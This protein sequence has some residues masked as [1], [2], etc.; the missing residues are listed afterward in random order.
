MEY[1]FFSTGGLGNRPNRRKPSEDCTR[2]DHDSARQIE[3][4][5]EWKLKIEP[6]VDTLEEKVRELESRNWSTQAY[7]EFRG[8]FPADKLLEERMIGS[9]QKMKD[10]KDFIQSGKV[11]VVLSDN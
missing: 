7:P 8:C 5:N 10:V 3:E 11:A 9:T 6:Q 4:V 2:I 1:R